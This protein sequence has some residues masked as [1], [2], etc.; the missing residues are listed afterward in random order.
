VNDQTVPGLN[1]TRQEIHRGLGTYLELGYATRRESD[2]EFNRPFVTL[3]TTAT[4]VSRVSFSYMPTFY[5][6]ANQGFNTNYIQT[7]LDSGLSDRLST[8]VQGGVETFDN[9]AI[10]WDAALE[11]RFKPVPS[12]LL[13]FGFQRAPIEESFLSTRGQNVAGLGFAGQVHSNL[14]DVG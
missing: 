7:T 14:A 2:L 1:E 8:H 5:S 12:T 3:S 9:A 10:N 4:G 11:A 6:V 13:K